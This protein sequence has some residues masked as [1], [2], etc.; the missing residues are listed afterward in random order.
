[1]SK[2]MISVKNIEEA[3][4]LNDYV[5]AY[6]IPIKDMSVNFDTYFNIE[7]ISEFI[8]LGKEV[9]VSM[10][11]N[12]FSQDLNILEDYLK[13]IETLNING[14]CYYDI[15]IPEIKKRLSLNTPLVWNQEHFVTNYETINYWYKNGATY[16]FLSNEITKEEIKEIKENTKSKLILQTF[17]Y[18]PMFFSKRPLITNYK[19]YFNIDD[20][21]EKYVIEKENKKYKV[22]ETKEGFEAYNSEILNSLEYVTDLDI[23]YLY[24]NNYDIDDKFIEVVKCYKENNIEKLNELFKVELGFLNNKTVYR[25]SDIK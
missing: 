25:V 13:K 10:N 16:A 11:K 22:R 4:L 7:D 3:K 14:I 20:D 1:M 6:L 5:D 24:L 12:M 8:K 23:D 17:G 15:A 19:K 21:S 2:I 18:V 9:F